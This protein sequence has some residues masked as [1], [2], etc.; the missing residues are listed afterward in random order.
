LKFWDGVLIFSSVLKLIQNTKK[1]QIQ[2][3]LFVIFRLLGSL[4]SLYL[5]FNNNV[6]ALGTFC[7]HLAAQVFLMS[8]VVTEILGAK[9]DKSQPS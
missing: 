4:A 3:S 8:S 6:D 7:F 1:L 9:K 5:D 2:K